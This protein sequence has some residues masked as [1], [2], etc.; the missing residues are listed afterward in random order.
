MANDAADMSPSETGQ[1]PAGGPAQ[2]C[3]GEA[4][5]IEALL[6]AEQLPGT[7]TQTVDRF[8]RPIAAAIAAAGKTRGRPL[9]IGIN[10]S[11]GSGKSTLCQCL[12]LLLQ[13]EHGLHAATLSL[14]DLYLTRSERMALAAAVHPLLMTRGVPGTHDIA[15]GA[16]VIADVRTGRTGMR[17]PRFDKARDDRMAAADWP[18]VAAKIDILLFEGWCVG[19]TPQSAAALTAPVNSLE[20]TEDAQG[21]WRHHVNTALEAPY[22]QLFAPIDL[23]VML[24]APRFEVVLGWR[25]LQEH[26]LRARTGNGMSPAAVKRF[27]MHFERLTRHMLAAM[28]DQ[29]DVLVRLDEHHHVTGLDFAPDIGER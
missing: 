15:L 6:A 20:A 4:A 14:D 28:P 1:T 27:V 24:A 9:V 13:A 16:A 17:L 8:W 5:A 11:Q 21:H 26:K 25:L 22:R 23:L 3:A 19:A 7:Y 10:G 29:A 18:V 12:E 2:S